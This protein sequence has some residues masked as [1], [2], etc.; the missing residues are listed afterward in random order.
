MSSK[1]IHVV[2]AVIERNNEV[3]IAKRPQHLHQ[4]GLWE[5]PGGKVE[6]HETP[7]QALQRELFEE[8]DIHVSQVQ[9]L[10]K[11]N[12]DYSDKSICLDVWR[13][14]D[15]AGTPK[16]KEGQEISWAPKH[17]LSRF[18]FPTANKPIIAAIVEP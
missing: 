3:F 7:Y 13:V 15:Y 8:I 9:P 18:S 4:G 16:G 5:F 6:S 2:A 17:S 14:T 12:H 1:R 11:I 10:I